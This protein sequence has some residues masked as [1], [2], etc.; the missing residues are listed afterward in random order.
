MK[1]SPFIYGT[2]VSSHAF[3]DRENET[4]KLYE[5]L[6][7]GINTMIIS[8]R[9]WGKSSL[10]EKVIAEINSKGGK[11]RTVLIDLFTVNSEEAFL[12]AFARAVIKASSSKWQEWMNSGKTFF[13]ALIPK[14]SVGLDPHTDF[15]VSFDW[16]ELKKHSDEILRLPETIC[17]K[18]GVEMIICLDEFQNLSSFPEYLVFEKKMRSV[19]QRQKSVTYCLFGSKRHMMTEIFNNPSKPFYRFGD[20]MLLSKIDTAKWESFI[21]KSF[22]ETGKQIAA[23][24][25]AR[26]ATSMKDHS[27]YVQQLAHY[28]WNLVEK[29]PRPPMLT[30]RWQRWLTPIPHCFKKKWRRSAT[31]NSTY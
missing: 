13:K 28:T 8:P 20:I 3:T 25:A 4:R 12:E 11:K 16:K 6:T 2:T 23:A 5:N 30:G 15:S 17:K 29:R 18:R 14:L 10:V 31:H 24:E 19:W 26:I 1:T 21:V 22:A 7:G 27:W 9:R